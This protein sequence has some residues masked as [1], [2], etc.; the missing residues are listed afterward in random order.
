M[1]FAVSQF[2]TW[3]IS[4]YPQNLCWN[5]MI[6]GFSQ[7]LLT[8]TCIYMRFRVLQFQ[9]DAR[10]LEACTATH[11]PPYAT[12]DTGDESQSRWSRRF[13]GSCGSPASGEAHLINGWSTL[14]NRRIS[15]APTLLTRPACIF[16][17]TQAPVVPWLRPVIFAWYAGMQWLSWFRWMFQVLFC[18]GKLLLHGCWRWWWML[19]GRRY[20]RFW[21]V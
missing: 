15:N 13:P 16:L 5:E 3:D 17:V 10:W 11:W 18:H 12:Q 21:D 14:S 9:L 2:D 7:V 4:S 8:C 20:L 1:G 6:I 19:G